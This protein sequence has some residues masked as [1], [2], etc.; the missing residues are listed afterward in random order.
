MS[1]E[2]VRVDDSN[3]RSLEEMKMAE[4]NAVEFLGLA[5]FRPSFHGDV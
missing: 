3:K 5:A 2:T 1:A 4:G